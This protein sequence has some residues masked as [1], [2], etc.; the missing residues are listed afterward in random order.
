MLKI[1]SESD[2]IGFHLSAPSKV[3]G[4]A[5]I[6]FSLPAGPD[7]SCPGATPACVGC[8]AQKGRHQMHNVQNSFARNLNTLNHYEQTD[9][10]VGCVKELSG[11]IEPGL[12]RIHESGD[13][14][15]QFAVDVWTALAALRDDVTFWF[16]TRSFNLDFSKLVALDN[17]TGWA[18]TDQYN[19]EQAKLFIEKFPSVR[20]AY[21]PLEKT[22]EVPA[23]TVMCPVT[24]GKLELDAACTKCKL[25][26]DKRMKKHIGFIKH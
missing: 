8:Y 9:N 24:T 3:G 1:I 25:C 4:R 16:Y 19:Q 17:V 13:F 11:L 22:D 2:S 26:T 12:F 7:F 10:L 14:H 15:S 23:N 5:K 18:S 20:H 6:A 21:G